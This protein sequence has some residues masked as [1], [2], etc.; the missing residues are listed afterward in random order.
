MKM[1]IRYKK[2]LLK[3]NLILGIIWLVWFF[4]RSFGKE[5]PELD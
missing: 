2:R 3:L 5:E 4:I 1:R